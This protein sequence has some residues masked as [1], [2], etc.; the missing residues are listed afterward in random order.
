MPLSALHRGALSAAVEPQS[1]PLIG[2]PPAA[3]TANKT[4]ASS[5]CAPL[6]AV[7]HA[8]STLDRPPNGIHCGRFHSSER[9]FIAGSFFP[10]SGLKPTYTSH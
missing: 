5:M 2:P 8:S 9:A 10:S 1:S 6:S 3:K 7:A 4:P